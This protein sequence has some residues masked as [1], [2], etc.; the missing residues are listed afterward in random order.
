MRYWE[1]AAA[2]RGAWTNSPKGLDPGFSN[3]LRT[4]HDTVVNVCYDNVV[5]ELFRALGVKVLDVLPSCGHAHS[6]VDG[7]FGSDEQI[8]MSFDDN[9]AW[10]RFT[11]AVRKASQQLG[12]DSEVS[13]ILFYEITNSQM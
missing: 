11:A 9:G 5:A 1:G 10:A 4:G 6:W 7:V 2:G 12:E 13:S 8:L 3:P